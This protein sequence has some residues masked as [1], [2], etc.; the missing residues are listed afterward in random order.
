MGR[1]KDRRKT[2]LSVNCDNPFSIFKSV[3]KRRKLEFHIILTT[4]ILAEEK[5]R[6]LQKQISHIYNKRVSR[7]PGTPS[8]SSPCFRFCPLWT[9]LPQLLSIMSK[10]GGKDQLDAIMTKLF[11]LSSLPCC[12]FGF[13][14]PLLVLWVVLDSF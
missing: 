8:A 5:K 7:C 10:L 1:K 4:Y 6:Y 11:M 3:V 2:I 12:F 13:R 14:H 9:R